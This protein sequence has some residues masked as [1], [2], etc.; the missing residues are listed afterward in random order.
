MNLVILTGRYPSQSSPY[1]HMFAHTRSKQYIAQGHSVTVLVPSES[2]YTYTIDGAVVIL[3]PVNELAKLLLNADRVM[4]H[5]LLHRFS[6]STDAG[7]LYRCVLDNKIPTLFFIHGVEAQTI[8]SDRRDDISWHS[9]KSIARWLYRDY[10][11]IKR[12]INTL[13][14]FVE[15]DMPVKFITPSKWM[16]KEAIKNTGVDLSKK[17]LVIANGIDTANFCFTERWADRDKLLSIRPLTYRGKYAVDLVLETAKRM[18]PNIHTALYG[19]GPDE[20]KIKNVA[21]KLNI[22][23]RFCLNSRFLQPIEIPKVHQ[24]AGIYLGVT[25]MDAQG[26]S[27]CE[28]MSSGLPTVSFST[29]AIPEF[30]EHNETGLLAKPYDMDEYSSLIG[31]LVENRSLFEKI[32]M[33]AHRSMVEIDIV[34]TSTQE[35]SAKLDVK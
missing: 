24:G 27:M 25:R 17:S 26:V 11:L 33:N 30:I 2:S 22:T 20:E 34:K 21:Q 7:V 15:S 32:A 8:W 14:E 35:L 16:L 28:A 3:G 1:S 31:E 23:N 6:K 9:P 18:P 29:C 19:M 13:T 10:Y 4:I 5:L 12:M